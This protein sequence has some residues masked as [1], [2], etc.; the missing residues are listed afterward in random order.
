M[1]S[2]SKKP[3]LN[4]VMKIY[5]A[6]SVRCGRDDHAIYAQIIEQLKR[7][8]T[9]LTEHLGNPNLT[10]QGEALP[11]TTIYERDMRWL[12]SADAVVAEVTTPSLG[13]GYEIGK[14]EDANK[15]I[16]CLRREA[17]TR[18]PSAMLVGNRNITFEKYNSIEDIEN[19][20][21]GFFGSVKKVSL[22]Q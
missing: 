4:K 1:R 12:M 19:I 11:E 18:P 14:A 10:T 21:E 6:G 17:E 2:D 3:L 7:F 16:L 8:G 20:L 9:V 13:V 15:P 22:E 5:F